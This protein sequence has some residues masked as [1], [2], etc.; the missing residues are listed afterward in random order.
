MWS[1]PVNAPGMWV[2]EARGRGTV[3]GPD[4]T[5]AFLAAN[6]LKLVIRSHEVR[7]WAR[8]SN[9]GGGREERGA[10]GRGGGAPSRPGRGHGPTAR[11]SGV[12]GHAPTAR[13]C[14]A[15]RVCVVCCLWCARAQ[16]PDARDKRAEGD[17][18]PPVD[19]GYALDHDTPAGAW[20]C[21]TRVCVGACGVH[22]CVGVAG[23]CDPGGGGGGRSRRVCPTGTACHAS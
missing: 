5:E 3:F 7:V 12:H 6:G 22:G 9:G 21:A 15:C 11:L 17:R 10:G 19:N 1:D 4:V 8:G 13:L 18:M 2:N 14:V 20:R 23:V 16:G